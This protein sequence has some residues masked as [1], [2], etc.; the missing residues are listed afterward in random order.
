MTHGIDTDFLAWLTRHQ[1]ARKRLL[2]TMLAATFQRAGV[3]RLLTHDD[4]NFKIFGCFEIV[5]FR[6]G[7]PPLPL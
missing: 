2:A 7:H 6:T 3:K 4:G 5:S 1:L